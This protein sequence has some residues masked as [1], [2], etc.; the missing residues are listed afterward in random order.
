MAF[1]CGSCLQRYHV[2]LSDFVQMV[3]TQ[4]GLGTRRANRRL[5]RGR[6]QA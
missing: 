3:T 1:H 5:R 6:W 2:N 4:I